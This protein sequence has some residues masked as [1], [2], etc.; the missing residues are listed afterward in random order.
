MA[1]KIVNITP[2][3][4]AKGLKGELEREARRRGKSVRSFVAVI[5]RYAVK[6]KD[7]FTGSLREPKETGGEHI[8][9]SVAETTADQLNQ[10]AKSQET[11][12]GM[13]CSFILQ[14]VLED[15][16]IDKIFTAPR[17]E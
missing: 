9:A 13:W 14:K 8:G 10:W 17:D 11:S 2:N 1:E 15:K 3:A 12:R 5:Y 6:N 4:S 16:L 7:K